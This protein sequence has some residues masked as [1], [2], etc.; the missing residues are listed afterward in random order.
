MA[1]LKS[2]AEIAEKRSRAKRTK[3]TPD[4]KTAQIKRLN[5]FGLLQGA[6]IF[7]GKPFYLFLSYF[8]LGILFI[9]FA[10]GRGSRTIFKSFYK[11]LTRPIPPEPKVTFPKVKLPKL[12]AKTFTKKGL[13]L[14]SLKVQLLL[15]KTTRSLFKPLAKLRRKTRIKLATEIKVALSLFFLLIFSFWFLVLRGLPSPRALVTR[16]QEVSTKIYDRNGILLYKIYKDK[17]RTL[18]RLN[19][20][21]THV[22]LATLAAEDAEFYAHPGISI[23]GII[24]ATY[25]NLTRGELTGGST[26]TQQL[27][28]NALLTPEK[29][30]IRKVK[31]VILSIGVELSFSKDEIFEM[32][33]NE[34][35]YGGTAYGLQEA[36]EQYFG[37]NVWDLTLSEAAML[38]GLPKSPTKFSPFGENP[39]LSFSRQKEVLRLMRIN[40]YITQ[41]EEEKA[42]V[43]RLTFAPDRTEIKAPHF[44]MYVRNQLVE[45]YGEEVVETGGLEVV[46]TLD[47][48]I[49]KLAE[50]AV[51]L[52]VQKLERLKVGNGAA[53]VLDPET[54]EILAMVGSKNYFDMKNDGNVNVT[55]RPRLPGSSIKVVNYAYAL[56]T[57]YTPASIIS[58]TPITYSVPGQPPYSPKN[59]DGE[60][61][62]NITLRSAL[63]ES[64][65][66]PAVKVLASYG[67]LKMI[68]Q[69]QKMGIT[70]WEDKSRFGLSLTLGGGEVKLLDLARVY[71]TVANSGKRPEI[72]STLEVKNYKGKV[73]ETNKCLAKRA[74]GLTKR[75]LAAEAAQASEH[76]CEGTEVLDPKVA[77]MLTD[78][79]KD[80]LARAPS[81]G[82]NSMLVVPGHPEVAVKTGTSNDL[83]DNL[84]VGFNQKYLVAVWV[85]NNDNA[86]MARIASGVT[87]AAPIWNKIMRGLLENEPSRDWIPPDGLAKLSICSLTGTLSCKSCAGRPEWFIEDKAPTRACSDEQVTRIL[88]EKKKL[89]E[90]KKA[91]GGQISEPAA[92]F[93]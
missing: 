2:F 65:N 26:I 1:R 18:I 71:A 84:T 61:R 20:V 51:S 89:E 75:V 8:V 33:L 62:G 88:E 7:V 40:R 43:E 32:Y 21:P 52:E 35:P 73:L 86:P 85:G 34:V 78:I 22:R 68:E 6:L 10:L 3:Q 77:F 50:A 69:G 56:S 5:P 44:V 39:E 41:E 4:E 80:N 48:E 15:I 83:R 66:I 90:A 23:R 64:R 55:I 46:T 13:R 72:T 87:G 29:T 93:P 54:G 38:A 42:S 59:Y 53:L 49:Q 27:V 58:D 74:V 28:K 25:R 92:R 36:A 63:A 14:Y 79:L 45:S 31:E 37:K 57:N 16:E 60:Y 82:S 81:F 30:I 17:N 24:R 9:L 76:S 67:V 11:Y 70:T 19:Q 12:E 91:S 47:W